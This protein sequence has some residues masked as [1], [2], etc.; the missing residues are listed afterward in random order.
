MRLERE[1]LGMGAILLHTRSS[2]AGTHLAHRDRMRPPLDARAEDRDTCR[3]SGRARSCV[4]T[5][6]TAAVRIS[7]I[8]EALR[9]A[10]SWP[11][12]PSWRSTAP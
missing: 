6:E 1:R 12:V 5:A 11:V 10:T 7:V 4:A 3:A 2:A 9:T 8:G